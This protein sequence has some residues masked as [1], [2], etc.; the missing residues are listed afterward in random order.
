[1]YRRLDVTQCR[2]I[3]FAYG[4][5]DLQHYADYSERVSLVRRTFRSLDEIRIPTTKAGNPVHPMNWQRN[6][7]MSQIVATIEAH[8]GRC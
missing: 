8:T 2:F 5:L 3:L 6:K 1:M 7:L 4:D